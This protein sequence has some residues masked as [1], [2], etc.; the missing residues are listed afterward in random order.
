MNRNSLR[1]PFSALCLLLFS[2][3]LLSGADGD[4]KRISVKN[5]YLEILVEKATGRFYIRTTGG[6]PAS[7]LDNNKDLLYNDIPGTSYT[8][9]ALD[10]GDDVYIFGSSQG[11][12]I[13]RPHAVKNGI[14]CEWEVDKCRIEQRLDF[15]KNS[16][17]GYSDAVKISYRARNLSGREQIIGL[18]V[19][20][21]TSLGERD[22]IFYSI[23]GYGRVDDERAFKGN[24][25][26][27]YWYS[28]DNYD[29]PGVRAIG[30][31]TGRD[32]D[33]P[34]RV[35]FAAWKRLDR[36][37]WDFKYSSGKSFKSSWLGRRDSSVALYYE[38]RRVQSGK[39]LRAS[40]K[41]GLYGVRR[42][43][44]RV[45][46]MELGG[47]RL[48]DDLRPFQIIADIQNVSSND[49]KDC[50]VKITPGTVRVK[51]LSNQAGS[52]TPLE[53]RIPLF[54]P[55]EKKR[56][57]W[58]LQVPRGMVGRI[59]YEV[60]VAGAAGR[61]LYTARIS[62][63][64]QVEPGTV[65]SNRPPVIR[66]KKP[67]DKG[68]SLT[69]QTNAAVGQLT[70]TRKVI[71]ITNVTPVQ[72]NRITVI[73]NQPVRLTNLP[74]K[75]TNRIQPLT[76][77]VPAVT[78]RPVGFTNRI[79]LPDTGG[80]LPASRLSGLQRINREI[81]AL[82]AGSRVSL[83][84]LRRINLLI[85]KLLEGVRVGYT[86]ED[87]KRDF[88]RLQQLL[89]QMRTNSGLPEGTGTP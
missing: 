59:P 20:L 88:D 79:Y 89:Q 41:F 10:A 27:Q 77:T 42:S 21:D 71:F 28:F 14:V 44:G 13:R 64:L 84:Q 11:K 39:E 76:N 80:R 57:N 75:V 65:I 22:G 51:S 85:D 69:Q 46:K 87:A 62:E 82:A 83:E 66:I 52:Y 86:E 29:R 33:P 70:N 12:W 31:L 5:D 18:R 73:T 72:T 68:L 55:Q 60:T 2:A 4:R 54:R 58:T 19:L 16:T 43:T 61:L 24:N 48:V 50:V 47:N 34:D 45:W 56:F 1:R 23:P 53:V 67:K 8:T 25:M 49:M 3:L 30:T 15:I 37:P 6:D 63:M 9:V 74:V 38:S 17:T 36:M 40:T 81:A 32:L 78:N 35:L 26:P 7:V